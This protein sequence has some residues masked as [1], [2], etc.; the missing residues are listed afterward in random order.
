MSR[1]PGPGLKVAPDEGR[2]FLAN[3]TALL[4]LSAG[5]LASLFTLSRPVEGCVEGQGWWSPALTLGLPPPASGRGRRGRGP[6]TQQTLSLRLLGVLPPR[7]VLP[8]L[9]GGGPSRRCAARPCRRVSVPCLVLC[10]APGA[11]QVVPQVPEAERWCRS[12]FP[13][14]SSGPRRGG[15]SREWLS[16]GGVE[17]V[18]GGVPLFPS[19]GGG[20]GAASSRSSSHGVAVAGGGLTLARRAP[21]VPKP[22]RARA[23]VCVLRRGGGEGRTRAWVRSCRAGACE[24]KKGVC[25]ASRACSLLPEPDGRAWGRQRLCPRLWPRTL[26]WASCLPIPQTPPAIPRPVVD[27]GGSRSASVG[28]KGE[29]DGLGDDAPSVRKPSLAIREGALGYRTPQPLPLPSVQWPRWR[30]PEHVGGAPRLRGRV[31]CAGPAVGAERRS[32][33]TAARAS[34]L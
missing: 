9:V 12:L 11:L 27:C 19:L 7:A 1:S 5:P 24:R 18:R 29:D 2:T 16:W 6:R 34:P 15:V 20:T 3:G 22:P 21:R 8:A 32:L 23:R 26:L 31:P 13:A 17:M 28:P 14:C 4:V 30:L 10:G 33:P 25:R